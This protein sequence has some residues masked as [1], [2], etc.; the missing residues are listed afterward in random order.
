[1]SNKN[2]YNNTKQVLECGIRALGGK[3]NERKF[4][5][6]FSSEEPC[7]RYFGIEILD[8]SE[9]CIDLTRLKE[10]GVVLFNHDRDN[11]LGKV[12]DVSV[13][14]GRGIA[15]IE[16]DKDDDAEKIYKKVVN[17]TLK[18]VS[19]GYVV[20]TWEEVKVGK[21]S[22]DG[23]F[24]GPCSIAKRWVPYEISIVSVPADITVGVGRSMKNNLPMY[25]KQI[26]INKENFERLRGK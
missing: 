7:K 8:H 21:T 9:G 1:M 2:K 23:R 15:T 25:E 17:G 12:L 20:D 16:F 26:K 19:I 4:S 18:G 24:V 13:Q 5:I 22:L 11:V 14:N 6:T 3:G 10:I